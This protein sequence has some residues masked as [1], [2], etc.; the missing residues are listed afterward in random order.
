MEGCDEIVLPALDGEIEVVRGVRI[1]CFVAYK[2][3]EQ[4]TIVCW[5]S[6]DNIR[7]LGV[8]APQEVHVFGRDARPYLLTHIATGHCLDCM[9]MEAAVAIGDQL[10]LQLDFDVET[11]EELGRVAQRAMPELDAWIEKL[12]RLQ[13]PEEVAANGW[14][15]PACRRS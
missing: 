11:V 2:A 8:E 14:P 5:G 7:R 6:G 13:T 1:G 9:T 15:R 12:R 3:P 10:M 4:T